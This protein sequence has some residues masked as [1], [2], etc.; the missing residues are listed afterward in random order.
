MSTSKERAWTGL[1]TSRRRRVLNA[2]RVPL[3][4]ASRAV[5]RTK[6]RRTVVL[7]YHSLGGGR[8]AVDEAAFREQMG[9]LRDHARTLTL[10]AILRGEH[11][12]GDVALNCAITFDDGYASVYEIAAPI[13][14]GFGFPALVYLTVG[15][16]GERTPRR[17]SDFPGL[18]ADETMLTWR[19]VEELSHNGLAFGSHLDHHK[20]LTS[21]PERE[22][23]RELAS[24]RS[25]ISARLGKP[26]THF[27]YPFG[28]FNRKAVKWVYYSGYES[29]VTVLH[30]ALPRRLDR[31]RIP[32]MCI[33]PLHDLREFAGMLAGEFDYLPSIQRARRVL[34]LPYRV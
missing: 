15:A 13:L 27:A 8:D 5:A 12:R 22:A 29:A 28:L 9:F 19:Q 10:P 16:I 14:H 34:R 17:A 20:D 24:S 11:L 25:I 33:A 7:A 1:A 30:K 32:R 31:L 23:L 21:L 4:L 6:P 2:L 26:C 3:R 18:F